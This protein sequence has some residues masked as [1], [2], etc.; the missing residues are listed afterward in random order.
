MK[1]A[2][3]VF[4]RR[5]ARCAAVLAALTWFAAGARAAEPDPF[6]AG[7]KSLVITYKVA[8]KD[9]PALYEIMSTTG[10]HLF[11]HWQ[12][13]GWIDSFHLYFGRN[14]DDAGWDLVTLVNFKRDTDVGHWTAIE[15][16]NPAGLPPA[17]ARLLTAVYSTPLDLVRSGAAP[18]PSKGKPVFMLIPYNYSPETPE[19]LNYLDTYVLPQVKG[20]QRAGILASYRMYIARYQPDRPWSVLFFFEYADEAALGRRDV[21]KDEVRAQLRETDP[22][23]KAASEHKFNI[24]TEHGI[25]LTEEI[26]P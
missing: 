25:T 1:F 14:A 18:K 22:A 13:E 7:P 4:A 9:R 21:V 5:A 11:Q 15:K 2:M 23:W 26:L 3:V 6:A 17:A 12:K 10:V 16:T 20:W 19:Y 24:R 8:P